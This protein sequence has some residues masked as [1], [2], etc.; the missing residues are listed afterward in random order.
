MRMARLIL[1]NEAAQRNL[2]RGPVQSE[3]QKLDYKVEAQNRLIALVTDHLSPT[4]INRQ[5]RGVEPVKTERL[6]MRSIELWSNIRPH[7][8]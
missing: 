3:R 1:I 4:P 8:L 5:R 2:F 6:I 7:Q